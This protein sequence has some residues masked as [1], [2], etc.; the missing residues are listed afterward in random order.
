[1]PGVRALLVVDRGGNVLEAPDTY[2]LK[3][4][5]DATWSKT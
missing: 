1:M 5:G 4:A 3:H 2:Y